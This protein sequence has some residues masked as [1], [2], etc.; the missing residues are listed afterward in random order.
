MI[1]LLIIV[2]LLSVVICYQVAKSRKADRWYWFFVA[3]LL[4]PIAIPFVFFASP[5]QE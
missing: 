1:G 2:T 4:G 3:L 5:R